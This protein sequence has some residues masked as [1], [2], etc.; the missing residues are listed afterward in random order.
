MDAM[1]THYLL[2]IGLISFLTSCTTGV[3]VATTGAQAV[4][5]RHNLQNTLGDH[6]ITMQANRKIY[7]DTDLF[8]NT[9]VSIATFHNEVLLTGEIPELEQ[10]N[11]ISNIVKNIPGVKK[12]YNLTSLNTPS[13][14]ITRMSDA[15]ITAKIKAKFIAEDDIDPSTIKVVTE[16]GTV[17]L[18]GIVF[19]EQANTAVQVARTTEGVQEVVKIFSYIKIFKA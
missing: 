13:S 14:S 19:P 2:L 8:K 9:N 15:W 16:N 18:M 7:R 6:Y 3:S 10:R 4:Y 11:E 12:V 1:K 17:Y 5:N